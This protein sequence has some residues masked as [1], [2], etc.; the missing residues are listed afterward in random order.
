MDYGFLLYS[1]SYNPL[2]SYLFGA[3]LSKVWHLELLKAD[4][5]VFFDM[6]PLLFEYFIASQHNRMFQTHLY[7][8]VPALETDISLRSLGS[9]KWIMMFKTKI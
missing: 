9:L 7:F 2:V 1:V 3:I 8:P 6:T 4:S 5:C